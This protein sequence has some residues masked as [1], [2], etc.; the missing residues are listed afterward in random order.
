MPSQSDSAAITVLLPHNVAGNTTVIVNALHEVIINGVKLRSATRIYV[1]PLESTT[2]APAA[3]LGSEFADGWKKLPDELKL[4][5]LAHNL[6]DAEPLSAERCKLEGEHMAD[7]TT[8]LYHHLR[9]TPEIAALA[10]EVFYTENTFMLCWTSAE[11]ETIDDI[12]ELIDG[13]FVDDRYEEFRDVFR[14]GLHEGNEDEFMDFLRE[15]SEASDK[16]ERI[17]YRPNKAASHLIRSLLWTSRDG[18]WIS[19]ADFCIMHQMANDGFGFTGLLDITLDL[20]IEINCKLDLDL[21]VACVQGEP[22]AF[23]CAGQ[24]KLRLVHV[25]DEDEGVSDS[26]L[27]RTAER[28]K[29]LV[30]FSKKRKR[31]D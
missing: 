28:V 12:D 16:H 5:V 4:K 23:K 24:F 18:E 14:D 10:K 26:D 11:N 9:T 22:I 1:T 8:N 21:L 20:D 17:F 15:G 27:A 19:S 2:I 6:V 29:E 3:P 30:T 25:P 31:S 7:V 13:D